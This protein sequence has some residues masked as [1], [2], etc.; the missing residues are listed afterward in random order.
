MGNM[1]SSSILPSSFALI[2]L[3]VPKCLPRTVLAPYVSTSPPL[4][5]WIRS[6]TAHVI[7]DPSIQTFHGDRC[8]IFLQY[9]LGCEEVD[10]ALEVV[11]L[12]KKSSIVHG[13]RKFQTIIINFWQGKR[14]L[15]TN[16]INTFPFYA[17]ANVPLLTKSEVSNVSTR[18]LP[19]TLCFSIAIPLVWALCNVNCNA[20]NQ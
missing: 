6:V 1:P 4:S 7:L 11:F 19:N 3:V 16:K 20:E 15:I 18:L 2:N 12:I 9:V 5:G 14:L 13:L 10:N 8:I 17:T